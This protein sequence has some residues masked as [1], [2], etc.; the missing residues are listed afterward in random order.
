MADLELVR[1]LQEG[2]EAWNQFVE[3]QEK[4]WHASLRNADLRNAKLSGANLL[5]A[6]L[7]RANLQRADLSGADLRDANLS[8]TDLS[9]TNLTGAMIWR[10]NLRLAYLYHADLRGAN[11]SGAC[12]NGAN[13]GFAN[14]CQAHLRGANLHVAN[15]Y[16]A[17]FTDAHLHDA[18]LC[19]TELYGAQLRRAQLFGA[20]LVFANLAGAN[21]QGADLRWAAIGGADLCGAN[22]DGARLTEE[23]DSK[24]AKGSFLDLALCRG[25]GSVKGVDLPAYLDR[26]FHFAHRTDTPDA[27]K[28][29]EFVARTLETIKALRQLESSE[30]PPHRLVEAVDI[31]SVQLIDYLKRHPHELYGIPPNIFEEVVGEVLA[32][33]GWQVDLTPKSKDGG[34]D[35][36]AISPTTAPETEASWIIECKRYAP[37]RPVGVDIVRALYGSNLLNR[38][39]QGAGMKML[40]TTSY[41]TAG[42]KAFKASRYDLAL[43]DYEG[44]LDWLNTYR[45]SPNGKLYLKDNR[46]VRG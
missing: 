4:G 10:A 22:L 18:N 32:S 39:D 21:L 29:P 9:L 45:P 40:A 20:Q 38:G 44:I 3:L 14:L 8:A 24:K 5:N 34:Y 13:L 46:L 26:A 33:Y 6:D 11:L 23:S 35:I 25:L 1:I 41:F 30:E 2:V 19:S 28:N 42:A 31:L 15:L 16:G 12:L 7:S 36:F 37:H 27:A 43:R 17:N